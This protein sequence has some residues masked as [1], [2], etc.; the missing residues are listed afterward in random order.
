MLGATVDEQNAGYYFA[1]RGSLDYKDVDKK[2]EIFMATATNSYG[3]AMY[4]IPAL[5]LVG[6]ACVLIPA[7]LKRKAK[8]AGN[9]QAD[10][11]EDR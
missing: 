5:E 8:K 11:E 4:L 3:F 7:F 6:A 1:D 10:K 9:K 2:A